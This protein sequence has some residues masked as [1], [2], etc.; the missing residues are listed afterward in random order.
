MIPSDDDEK[1]LYT[2]GS[3]PLCIRYLS[4]PNAAA[5]SLLAYVD[6]VLRVEAGAYQMLLF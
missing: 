5:A 2:R 6:V 4:I 3:V 1:T